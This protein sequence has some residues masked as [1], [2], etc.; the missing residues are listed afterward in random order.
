[1]SCR[2]SRP[3]RIGWGGK[4]LSGFH[5]ALRTGK[6]EEFTGQG[7]AD[8]S[9]FQNLSQVSS[10]GDVTASQISFAD[11]GPSSQPEAK[12]QEKHVLRKREAV[13]EHRLCS[14]RRQAE[15]FD[16]TGEEKI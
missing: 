15:G 8:T 12:S 16:E 6:L 9:G 5:T 1:M 2:S 7:L 10:V 11:P 3:L 4:W 13:G 14:R